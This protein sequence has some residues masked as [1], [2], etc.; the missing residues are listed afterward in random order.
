MEKEDQSAVFSYSNEAFIVYFVS[1]RDDMLKMI[2]WRVLRDR[3]IIRSQI[4][5]KK[6]K[7][8][9]SLLEIKIIISDFIEYRYT[10]ESYRE[11]ECAK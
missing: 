8:K 10:I 7:N 9:N 1:V 11:G 3:V 6:M 2:C 4:K 5:S